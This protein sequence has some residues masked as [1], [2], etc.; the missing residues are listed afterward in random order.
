MTL[1]LDYYNAKA[2]DFAATTVAV[3]FASM[4]DRFMALLPAGARILDFGCGSGRDSKRFLDEGFVV[5]ATDG[6]PE[7]C[8]IASEYAGISVR[9]ELFNELSA[10]G[11]YD[12]IWACASILHVPKDGLPDILFKM[13]RAL[14]LGGIAYA[15]FKY[16]DFDG[17]RAGRYFSDFVEDTFLSVVAQVEGLLVDDLWVTDDMRPEREGEKWL[18]CLISRG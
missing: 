17:M 4:Q 9:N 18:N 3:D 7:L 13:N 11:R 12:G 14:K 6:C 8:R 10:E 15:S 1:T 2:A 5:E 16:G